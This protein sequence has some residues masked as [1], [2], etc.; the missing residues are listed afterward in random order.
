[1]AGKRTPLFEEHKALGANMVDFGGWEMPV[2]YNSILK[3]HLATREKAGLFDVSHMG[4]ILLKGKGAREALNRLVTNDLAALATGGVMYTL[5]PNEQGGTVDDLLVYMLAEEALL[6]VVNAANTDKDYAWLR[7]KLTA[8]AA[9]EPAL[10]QVT[11]E[12]VSSAYAQLAIQGPAA[13]EILQQLAACDLAQIRFFRCLQT[14]VLNRP[15]ILSRTGYTGEDG[16]ELYCSPEDA[17][18]LWRALL[19]AGGEKGLLPVGLGARDTLRFEA[20]L[21][22][23]GHELS[24]E[25]TAVEAGLSPFVKLDKCSWPGKEILREQ[26]VNGPRRI[27]A[28]LE[29][30]ER[31]IPRQGYD[32]ARDG[33]LVGYVASG[34]YSPTFRKGLA[35]V[36]V[37][38][39]LA[40]PGTELEVLLRD[41]PVKAKILKLPFYRKKT[42]QNRP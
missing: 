12:N 5:L 32:V 15:V 18:G 33:S 7:Q 25:I 31:G 6:L 2:Q 17:P 16:F 26:L 39:E 28:G 11:L 30:L 3:E 24:D 9:Q 27:L 14:E 4:E 13:Q 41:N 34:V 10:G 8:L 37:P 38:P 35:T 19:E 42:K 22:L 21:P 36:F 20:A 1:M 40:A 23:Y 29:L